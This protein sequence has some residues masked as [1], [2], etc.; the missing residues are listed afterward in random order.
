[1]KTAFSRSLS[2]KQVMST[3]GII[4]GTIRN[5]MVDLDSGEVINL[6]VKPEP[7]F[8]TSGY[9]I[10]GDRLFVPFEAVRDIRDYIVVDRYLSKQ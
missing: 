7:N 3:D 9:T 4:I 5:I 8:D 10:D 1:M 2:K 6:V